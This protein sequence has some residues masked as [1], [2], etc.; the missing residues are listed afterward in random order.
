[1]VGSE[2]S[3]IH[4]RPAKIRSFS[5]LVAESSANDGLSFWDVVSLSEWYG[6]SVGICHERKAGVYEVWFHCSHGLR[7]RYLLNLAVAII[8]SSIS[9]SKQ[10]ASA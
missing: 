4:L 5:S 6:A 9:E 10:N 2:N 3:P 7:A 1:V 8:S